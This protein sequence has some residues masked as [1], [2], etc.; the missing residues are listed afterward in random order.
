M[1]LTAAL[2]DGNIAAMSRLFR[3]WP[4]RMA[5]LL[6]AGVALGL[7]ADGTLVGAQ[8]G[9]NVIYACVFDNPTGPNTRIVPE[10][11]LPCPERSVFTSWSIQGPAGPKGAAGVAGPKGAPGPPG[12]KGFGLA[13]GV[14]KTAFQWIKDG[15]PA[16]LNLLL[17]PGKYLVIAKANID[18]SNYDCELFRAGKAPVLDEGFGGGQEERVASTVSV[19]RLV[20]LP[21]GGKMRLVCSNYSGKQTYVRQ[22]KITAIPLG[23]YFQSGN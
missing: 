6:A 10:T 13:Q 20:N 8:S 21:E 14:S 19:Q 18:G 11:E 15:K 2:G 9:G 12:P 16:V 3:P 22:R 23:G 1:A 4:K 7:L 17:P 5:G